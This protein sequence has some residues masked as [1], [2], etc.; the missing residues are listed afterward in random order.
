MNQ[1]YRLFIDAAEFEDNQL[2]LGTDLSLINVAARA[3]MPLEEAHQHASRMT[4]EGL[5]FPIPKRP[6]HLKL[7]YD[8]IKFSR[9]RG[10]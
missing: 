8:A 2:G 5:A 10:A 4:R 1:R 7:D 6:D 9:R 3:K